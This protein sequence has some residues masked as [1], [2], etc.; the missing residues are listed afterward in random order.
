M[1]DGS[2]RG[3]RSGPFRGRA[4]APT[5]SPRPSGASARPTAVRCR[6]LPDSVLRCPSGHHE[7]RGPSDRLQLPRRISPSLRT[8]IGMTDIA[9]ES[10]APAKVSLVEDFVDILFSP[11]EV[12]ARREKSGYALVMIIVTLLIGGLA[13]ANSGTM[14]DLMEAEMARGMAEAM[15]QNPGMTQEQAA[16]GRKISGYVMT[17]GAFIVTPVFMFLTGLCAWLTAKML[18]G[19]LKYSAATMI[20]SYSFIPRVVESLTISAQGLLIDTGALTGQFQLSL[21][22]ARF[23]DPEMSPGL[24]G[25]L[26]RIDVFTLWV[27]VLFAIGIGVV[28]KLPR[29]KVVVAGVM[30]WAFG[31][32]P[33]LW[34]LGKAAIFG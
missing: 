8:E 6:P 33:S 2:G 17:F 32:L 7:L 25:L 24:L 22:V 3:F 20:A 14:Q 30:M 18:G 29:D 19:S 34:R 9:P 10:P 1:D 16:L 26:G 28:A 27:T 23:L 12:F 4:A 21:G 31:A 11:R 13:I 15:K 5:P